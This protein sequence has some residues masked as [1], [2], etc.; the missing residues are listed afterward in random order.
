MNA[1]MWLA[2]KI[3]GKPLEGDGCRGVGSF[4]LASYIPEE[5]DGKKLRAAKELDRF[6]KMSRELDTKDIKLRLEA[7]L[8][9]VMS[10][11]AQF[12]RVY[13]LG[14]GKNKLVRDGTAMMNRWFTDI[15]TN[16]AAGDA[17]TTR[18][19]HIQL[20]IDNTTPHSPTFTGCVSPITSPAGMAENTGAVTQLTGPGSAYNFDMVQLRKTDFVNG[21]GVDPQITVKEAAIRNNGD[22]TPPTPPRCCW[23][24]A[25]TTA[26]AVAGGGNLDVTYQFQWLA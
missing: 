22:G 8:D 16:T 20:G 1:R 7:F 21:T 3:A 14:F 23:C 13:S 4:T 9:E 17:I 19:S 18:V 5:Q 15:P 11:R 24:R 6:V 12:A 10:D 26:T 2:E 25:T